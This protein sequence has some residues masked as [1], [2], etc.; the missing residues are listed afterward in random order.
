MSAGAISV[1]IIGM[2]IIWGGLAG[3]IGYAV[4]KGKDTQ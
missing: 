1:M 2:V 3:S 4:K